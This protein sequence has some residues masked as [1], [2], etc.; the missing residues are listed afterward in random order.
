MDM[1]E[2]FNEM[3]DATNWCLLAEPD[4]DPQLW[5]AE[6]KRALEAVNS[7][8]FSCSWEWRRMDRRS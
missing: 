2:A 8:H 3:R 7:F 5:I 1:N 6:A 4:D